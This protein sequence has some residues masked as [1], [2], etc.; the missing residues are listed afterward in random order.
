MTSFPGQSNPP[1]PTRVRMAVTQYEV[2]RRLEDRLVKER[3]KLEQ[4]I[5]G[6]AP[7]ECSEYASKTGAGQ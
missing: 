2:V 3:E 4:R 6:F 1:E 7:A 5:A